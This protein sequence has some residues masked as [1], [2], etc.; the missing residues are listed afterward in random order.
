MA[1]IPPLIPDTASFDSLQIGNYLAFGSQSGY[2][3]LSATSGTYPL[4]LPTSQGVSGTYLRNNGSG[5][6]AWATPAGAGDVLGP[7]SS[8]TNAL[9][10]WADTTGTVLRNSSVTLSG[11]N[12]LAGV[13]TLGLS[14]STSGTLSVRPAAVTTSYTVTMPGA[15]GSANT[16]AVNDGTGALTWTTLPTSVG[17]VT[18]PPSSTTNGVALYSDT[19]GTVI[20]NS[21]VTISSTNDIANV[22]SLVLSGFTSGNLTVKPAATTTSYTVTMPG[23][24]SATGITSVLT[25]DGTGV[26]SWTSA[27]LLPPTIGAKPATYNLQTTDQGR[28]FI[29]TSGS[30]ILNYTNGGI[31]AGF[32]CFV[33]NGASSDIDLQFGGVAVGGVTPTLHRST[34]SGNSSFCMLYYDGTTLYLY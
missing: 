7:G 8:T 2:I 21:T 30:G 20:K 11:A 29:Y 19:T 10:L 32:Y 25:N 4:V 34:G 28:N 14:G 9:A 17:N 13:G 16:V 27:G 15:Q 1:A 18:G 23:A 22:K 6:L 5:T 3:T 26:L 31:S 24:Q 33:K 12:V